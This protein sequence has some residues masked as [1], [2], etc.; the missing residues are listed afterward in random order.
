MKIFLV[1]HGE[2]K[3]NQSG[4]MQNN[5][6]GLSIN[7]I[8]Q[9]NKLSK[10]LS[11]EKIDL[12]YSSDFK[13]AKITA[14][15]IGKYHTC[16]IRFDKRLREIGVGSYVGKPMTIFWEDY[17]KNFDNILNWKQGG[18]ESVTDVKNRVINFIEYLEN[19]YQNKNII[20]VTHGGIIEMFFRYVEDNFKFSKFING[21]Y[22]YCIDNC[23]ISELLFE[24]RKW[25]IIKFNYT[26]HLK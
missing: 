3:E 23:S 14:E 4:I 9:I 5:N 19:N 22:P 11:K 15:E 1:R 13:R 16:K 7:G 25:E 12:I 21:E 10:F 8:L 17:N 18:E 20:I 24:N 6:I 2:T 26:E